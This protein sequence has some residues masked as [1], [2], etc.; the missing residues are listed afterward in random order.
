MFDQRYAVETVPRTVTA[1]TE[2]IN[3]PT[4]PVELGSPERMWQRATVLVLIAATRTA[5]PAFRL[6][7]RALS[8]AHSNGGWGLT[9]DP[10]GRAVF[11]GQDVD[12]SDTTYRGDKP[13]DLLVN[14]P[15]WLPVERFRELNDCYELGYLYWWDRG[16]W[17]RAPYPEFVEDDGLAASCDGYA[18]IFDDTSLA[19]AFA[20][21]GY[22]DR[23]AA[24]RFV[25]RVEA[26]TVNE[27]AL[28]ELMGSACGVSRLPTRARLSTAMEWAA[29]LGV[30]A[31][32]R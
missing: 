28:H 8:C 9:L 16:R 22:R 17:G 15:D 3:Q 30:A 2:M 18:G 11:W 5:R 13:V 7:E 20:D 29:R 6:H 12:C 31:R 10:G 27:A 14:A 32:A 4:V 21:A 1:G 23:M 26:G 19:N 24:E 25:A